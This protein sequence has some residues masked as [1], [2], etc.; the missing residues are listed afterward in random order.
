M[1]SGERTLSDL[2]SLGH[3]AHFSAVSFRLDS[4]RKAAPQGQLRQEGRR[5]S[6]QNDCGKALSRELDRGSRIPPWSGP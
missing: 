1:R 3:Q 2:P 4:S 6:P 5:F